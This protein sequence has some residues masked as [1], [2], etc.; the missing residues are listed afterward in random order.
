MKRLVLPAVAVAAAA[1]VA[2]PAP[3]SA[4]PSCVSQSVRSEHA[5]Y[6]PAWGHDVIAMLASNRDLLR[7]FGFDSF[8]KLASFGAH[9]DTQ[10][11]P[12]DL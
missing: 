1:L 12:P 10:N 7:T 11:C 5:V 6:G 3:A 4:A 9:H 8:G 2:V